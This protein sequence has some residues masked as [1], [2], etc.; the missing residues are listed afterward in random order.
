LN[1]IGNIFRLTIYGESHGS[2]IG[3][4]IDRCP[5]GI[6]LT[7]DEIENELKRRR[8]GKKGTT[9]RIESDEFEFISGIFNEYSTGSPINIMIKNSDKKSKDYSI[10]HHVPRPGHADHT[11]SE[12]YGNFNDPRG[13]GMFSGRMTACLVAAGTIAKKV[14]KPMKIDSRIHS[15]GGE[16]DYQEIIDKVQAEGDSVGGIIETTITNMEKG[17]GEPFFNS[18]ESELSRMIFS[19]PAIKGI[20]F[21]AGFASASLKGS[22]MNDAIIDENGKTATNNSGGINGGISN[23]NEIYFRVAVKPTSSISMTQKTYNNKSKQVEG[24]NIEG[25]HDACIALRVPP[26]IEAATAC[27]LADLK[28]INKQYKGN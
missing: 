28:L 21:G 13:G 2:H 5:P 6:K 1:S 23:G 17:I 19:I 9:T 22:E 14:I 3:I 25:R 7:K 20:E 26:I 24:F 16:K 8:P 18:F 10:F 4:I 27:V 15:I 11:A 12:K